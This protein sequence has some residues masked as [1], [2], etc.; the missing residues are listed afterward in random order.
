MVTIKDVSRLSG[1]SVTTVSKVLNN[2][3]DISEATRVKI[4]DICNEVGYVPNSSARSLKTH[5]SYTIGIVFEEETN[6]GLNHPL[7]SR[8]LESFKREAEKAGYDI[9]FLARSMGKQNGSYLEHSKRKQVEGVLVLCA[10]FNSKEIIELS[11]SDIPTTIIDFAVEN[12]VNITSDNDKGVRL[13]INHLLALGHEKIAHIYG[14]KDSLIGGQRKESFEA[15]LKE[16][17]LPVKEDYLVSGEF[18]S[19]EEGREAMAELL[20]LDTPPTAVFCASD[21]LAIGA[22]EAA[23]AAGKLVPEDCSIIGFDGIDLGQMIT[24]RLTTVKQDT[25]EMGRLAASNMIGLIESKKAKKTDKTIQ[26]DTSLMIGDS[27]SKA[28]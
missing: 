22:V 1:F 19:R 14:D 13:A 4:I 20:S 18:F 10:D 6:Q 16:N 25:E 5:R 27:T 9:M 28:K 8:I 24:P 12:T 17:G 26:V 7:F 11:E 3:P 21:M 23:K 2:Y 15:V